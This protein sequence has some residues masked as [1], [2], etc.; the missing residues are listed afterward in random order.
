MDHRFFNRELSWLAFNERVL[1]EADRPGLPLLERCKFLAITSANLDE[2][3]M[4]RVGGLQVLADQGRTDS[5]D[6][7]LT[8]SQQLQ[9][10]R[11]KILE[12]IDRQYSILDNQLRPLLS[13]HG[14]RRL[15]PEDLNATQTRHVEEY[16]VDQLL[17][18]LS[19]IAIDPAQLNLS[20]PAM[21]LG[22][23]VK[24]R[25]PSSPVGPPGATGRSG[26]RAK[27]GRGSKP[28]SLTR[29]V[30]V[31]LPENL[32]RHVTVPDE[33]SGYSY[34]NLEDVVRHCLKWFFPGEKILSTGVFRISRNGDIGVDDDGVLDLADEMEGVLHARKQSATVRLEI[35]PGVTKEL[36]NVMRRIA[37]AGARQTYQIPGELDLRSYF[38]IAGLPMFDTLKVTPWNPR[39]SQHLPAGTNIFDAIKRSDLLLHHP[40]ESFDPVLQ[41]I[42]EAA[43]DPDVVAIKQIL[44]RTAKNSRIISA[45]IKAAEDGKHVTVLVEL[46]A[47]FDEARNLERAEELQR[48]GAQIIYGVRGLKT[49][50]KCLLVVRREHGAIRRYAHFG[51]GNYNEA[52]ARIY[53]DISYLTARPDYGA[54]ASAFFNTVT[55]LS[56]FT[57]FR[58]LAMAPYTM[59]QRLLDLIASESERASHGEQAEIILKMNSLQ[60]REMIEALYHASAAGVRVRLNVRGICCLVPGEKGLSENIEVISV[61]DRYLEHARIFH[62]H[63]GGNPVVFIAS[64]DWMFRNL[65]R[66]VELM[67]PVEDPDCRSELVSILRQQFEDNTQA[68]RLLS[69]GRYEPLRPKG[70]QKA[71]RSQEVFNNLAKKRAKAR[72]EEPA[73]LSPHLPRS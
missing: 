47:R 57:T 48:A 45:L 16:F 34:I 73:M 53:T 69:D 52:T 67:V 18:L 58:R 43:V 72:E 39:P 64:A 46:K 12:L 10:I 37:G 7:G 23:L 1:G 32:S 63:Q 9:L 59:R 40:Y 61:I 26:R 35:G 8:P 21:Q 66:R 29:Y 28:T 70:R 25:S 42:E 44:Y 5:D 19:P 17:P 3:F 33:A 27:S 60:D 36:V 65:S 56:Q 49:H 55:G 71:V 22:L 30:V 54:D 13:E 41:L 20:I 11:E 51:T 62:F 4:I 24:V 50:A 68:H 2:F 31:F 38:A 6:A 14:I 15:Q